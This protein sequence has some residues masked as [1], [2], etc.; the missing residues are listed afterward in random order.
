M[1]V[2]AWPSVFQ[3]PIVSFKDYRSVRRFGT[4]IQKG[5]TAER[6]SEVQWTAPKWPPGPCTSCIPYESKE[7]T[8]LLKGQFTPTSKTH[9]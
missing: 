9:I 4:F 1:Y 6:L 8:L 7:Q 5:F 2:S 3:E